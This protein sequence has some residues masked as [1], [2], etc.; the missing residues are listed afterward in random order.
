MI[1]TFQDDC[2]R[3][4]CMDIQYILEEA[5]EEIK[6]EKLSVIE[7]TIECMDD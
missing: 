4:K 5:I 2:G 6:K 3:H 1:K 7:F